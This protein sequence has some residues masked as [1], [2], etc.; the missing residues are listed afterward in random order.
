M[1]RAINPEKKMA[2]IFFIETPIAIL[3]MRS[4]M[5]AAVDATLPFKTEAGVFGSD[6]FLASL[7]KELH[8]TSY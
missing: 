3:N 1:E 8:V 7:G 6:D 5:E 4:I 2:F